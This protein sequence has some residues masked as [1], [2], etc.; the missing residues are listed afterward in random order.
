M[1]LSPQS[2]S[3][4]IEM[5]KRSA[6]VASMPLTEPNAAGEGPVCS[7]T[8]RGISTGG[9]P[10]QRPAAA[11]DVPL[12]QLGMAMMADSALHREPA[13]D[14]IA[15]PFSRPLESARRRRLLSS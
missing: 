10:V 5:A 14:A 15:M 1:K 4:V 3:P 13:A 12:A 11:A 7:V 9:R 8:R 2:F 6:E